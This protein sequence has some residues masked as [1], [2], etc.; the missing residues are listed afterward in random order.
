M[1]V[2]STD[3][4]ESSDGSKF[5]WCFLYGVVGVVTVFG[6]CLTVAIFMKRRFK[7]RKLHYILINLAITDLS[8]GALSVPL[9]IYRILFIHQTSIY[10]VHYF[11]DVLSGLTSM[12]SITFISIERLMAVA[13]PL[14]HRMLKTWHYAVA[15]SLT[16]LIAVTVALL[17]SRPYL[18]TGLP[19][20][21]TLNSRIVFALL[22]VAITILA[23]CALWCHRQRCEAK[24]RAE[25]S[26]RRLASTLCIV[27]IIFFL[28]WTP[29][30]IFSSTIKYF[31]VLGQKPPITLTTFA[32][33]MYL[34]KLLQYSNSCV[35]PFI[36]TLRIPDFRSELLKILYF[37]HRVKRRTISTS[38]NASEHDKKCVSELTTCGTP[39]YVVKFRSR[40]LS[41]TDHAK[42]LIQTH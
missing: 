24:E 8:V 27:T 13:F 35:N 18:P 32:F 41:S 40:T 2:N 19:P 42:T 39:K 30:I 22:P 3:S 25:R 36:Y 10:P 12:Y 34:T 15:I 28:T 14:K 1:G 20:L 16:W 5:A 29:F 6:N 38:F 31:F 23:Y 37:F 4:Y 7:R 33:V 9:Q 21:V 17:T 26:N 11:L